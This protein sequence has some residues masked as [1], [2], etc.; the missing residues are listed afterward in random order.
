MVADERRIRLWGKFMKQNVADIIVLS[1]M[2]E[3]MLLL[4]L[5]NTKPIRV[6][7]CS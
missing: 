7:G 6:I 3:G 2:R 4:Y 1:P 5:V